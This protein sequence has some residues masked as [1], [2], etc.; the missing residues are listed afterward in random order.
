MI[1]PLTNVEVE[2]EGFVASIRINRPE[3]RNALDD[4]TRAELIEAL[5]WAS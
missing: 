2:V 1:R 5:D 3:R 4:V